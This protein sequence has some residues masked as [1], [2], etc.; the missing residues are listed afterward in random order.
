MAVK[1]NTT[2]PKAFNRWLLQHYKSSA[3]ELTIL[4]FISIL[5]IS[6]LLMTPWPLKVLVDS[7]FGQTSAPGVL[8][9]LTE[10]Q[11][12]IL[13][14]VAYVL[15]YV[16]SGLVSIADQY[17]TSKYSLRRGLKLKANFFNHVLS[18]N[19]L[20]RRKVQGGDYVYR[21]NQEVDYLPTLILSTTTSI[22]TNVITIIAAAIVLSILNAQ[23]AL[24]S[25]LI[26][27]LLYVSIKI[28][29]PRIGALSSKL[30]T[31]SSLIYN[32]STESIDKVEIVQAFNRE[33]AQTKQLE[34]LVSYQN[35]QELKLNVLE[36]S[37]EFSNNLFTSIGVGIVVILG[38]H[39]ALN[40]VLS[41]GELLIFITYMSYFYDPLEGVVSGVGTY[42]SLTAGL[43]RV[44]D[45]LIM[46]R[47]K[48]HSGHISNLP[49]K[50]KGHLQFQ[51]VSFDYDG[52]DIL[53][54]VNLEVKTGEKVALIG[55]SGSGKTT[56]L[57]LLM[58]YIDTYSGVIKI[59]GHDISTVNLHSLRENISVVTQESD[60]FSGTVGENI[61]FA[62]PKHSDGKAVL[63]AADSANATEFIAKIPKHFDADI[64]ES[65]DNLSGGQKQRI[66]IAR[67]FFKDSPILILDEPTSSQ[68]TESGQKIIA[69]IKELMK[70]KTV[71][72]VSHE[73]S[74]LKEMD[75]VYVMQD[76]SI[77]NVIEYG[78]LENYVYR[79]ITKPPLAD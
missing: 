71:L 67:A 68:D 8:A 77:K 17:L 52:V 23:L 39:L 46:P 34:N 21:L 13:V 30:E 49:E 55:Q 31:A 47:V 60:L 65:G 11:L 19:R 66:S 78:G 74:L 16:A 42:K 72:M 22:I 63:E 2:V 43:V 27:P 24:Y 14:G 28:F 79:L 1:T 26:V 7:V 25:L 76:G 70:N 48:K 32:H 57:S 20:S 69:A 62:E 50:I 75:T 73:L 10:S 3:G 45:I 64:G 54:S 5:S 44:H 61:A 53:K 29:T 56:L 35:K 58:G 59:D 36:S 18:M 4:V 38:G 51:N 12:L 15:I 33:K 40:G 41:L 37:F 9:D 6:I